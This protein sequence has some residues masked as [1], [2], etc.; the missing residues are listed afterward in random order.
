MLQRLANCGGGLH[1]A[2]EML[3]HALRGSHIAAAGRRRLRGLEL[4]ALEPVGL[5]AGAARS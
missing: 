5:D 1:G 4:K 3:V 2:G